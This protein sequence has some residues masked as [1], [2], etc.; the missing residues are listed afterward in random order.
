MTAKTF[1]HTKGQMKMAKMS[2]AAG[3]LLHQEVA[4]LVLSLAESFGILIFILLFSFETSME[5]FVIFFIFIQ[6]KQ[7]RAWVKTGENES[8]FWTN[9]P[10]ISSGNLSPNWP[11]LSLLFSSWV[12]QEKTT[13]LPSCDT[14]WLYGSAS[15]RG[16]E[17]TTQSLLTCALIQ[18]L[19]KTNWG[20]TQVNSVKTYSGS[21]HG[22]WKGIKDK[23]SAHININAN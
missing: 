10:Y 19:N 12:S 11:L 16:E 14:V 23:F 7:L 9:L 4:Q 3:T 21:S 2:R 17:E 22:S 8:K 20:C 15:Q 5:N 13:V 1:P 18:I 6:R